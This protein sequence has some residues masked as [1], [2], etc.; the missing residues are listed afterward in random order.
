MEIPFTSFGINL[1]PSTFSYVLGIVL[2][3][4]H[5]FALN[6]LDD[7]IVFSRTSEDHLSH[8][9]EVFKQLKHAD[10]KIKCSKCKF[11]KS[12]VHYLGYIVG[13]DGV[14][15]LPEKLEAIKK[16]LAPTNLDE[17]HQLLGFTGF[18]RK[19]VP[20]YA[21]IT[22]CLSRLLRK[23]TNFQWSEQCNS[24]F[25]VLK[26]ELCKMPSLQ[27]PDCNKAF[28][29]FTD[30]S[31]YSYSGILNQAQGE[32]FNQLI[33]IAYFSGCFKRTQQLWNVTQKECYTMYKSVNNVMY[34]SAR[35]E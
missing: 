8:L 24:A 9:E 18:Y 34:G 25:N 22:N 20:F 5:N 14:Q 35:C 26:E 33:P 19:F 2:A 12:K 32:D 15:L 30:T 4:C 10:L 6:Y 3:P 16:L 17:L 1:G 11:F 13:V 27:Y 7:I 23:G 31:N 21:D 29:L 28:K